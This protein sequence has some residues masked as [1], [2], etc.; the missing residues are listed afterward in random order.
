MTE[1]FGQN[2]C[3]GDHWTRQSAAS[4]FIDSGNA[5]D[6]DGAKFFLVTKTAAPVHPRKSLSDFHA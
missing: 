2:H 1:F 6:S 4:C 5:R 3:S